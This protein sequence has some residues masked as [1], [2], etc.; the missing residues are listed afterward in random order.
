MKGKAAE[1]LFSWHQAAAVPPGGMKIGGQSNGTKAANG[2]IVVGRYNWRLGISTSKLVEGIINN[3]VVLSPLARVAGVSS[4]NIPR[5]Y[6]AGLLV[7][8]GFATCPH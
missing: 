4:E 8:S 6:V 2:C 1:S 3:G 7:L 5:C